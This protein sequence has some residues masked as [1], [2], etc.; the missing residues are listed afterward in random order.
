MKG[1]NIRKK[2]DGAE[3]GHNNVSFLMWLLWKVVQ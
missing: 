3:T 2:T 1:V